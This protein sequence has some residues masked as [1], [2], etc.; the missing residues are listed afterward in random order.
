MCRALPVFAV[1][2]LAIT[3]GCLGGGTAPADTDTT[4]APPTT[5]QTATETL[6]ETTTTS[7]RQRTSMEYPY[8]TEFVSVDPLGNQSR[9]DVSKDGFAAFGNLTERRQTVFLQALEEG[10][11]TFYPDGDRV[12]PFSYGDEDRP[13]YVRYEGTWY[14]V[15]VAIV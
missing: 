10:D 15:R 9:G 13:R 11:Q 1:V 14:Y 12:N 4:D 2:A 5:T 3:A 6:T 7:E 8:G